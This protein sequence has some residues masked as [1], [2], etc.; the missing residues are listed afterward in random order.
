VEFIISLLIKGKEP[1]F[2][3]VNISIK[4]LLYICEVLIDAV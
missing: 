1:L 3:E 4:E 2:Q